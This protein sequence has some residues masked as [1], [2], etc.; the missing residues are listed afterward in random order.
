MAENK[1]N[2]TIYQKI[3]AIK[4]TLTHTDIKKSGKNKFANY[5]YM[6]LGDFLPILIDLME[7]HGI[8]SKI[9][10]TTDSATLTLMDTESQANLIY[11]SP[12]SNAELKGAQNI[13]NLGATQTYLRRYLYVNAFDI[14]ENDLI[15]ATPQKDNNKVINTPTKAIVNTLNNSSKMTTEQLH[16]IKTLIGSM[17]NKDAVSATLKV[18]FGDSKNFTKKIADEVIEYLKNY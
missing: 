13:Q 6:E 7:E 11:T 17:D 4:K 9:D 2:K 14:V 1:T 18:E 8:C 5:D 10:F 15:D 12:V 16:E 3:N